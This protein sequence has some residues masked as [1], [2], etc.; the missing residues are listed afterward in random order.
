MEQTI[1]TMPPQRS[2]LGWS[3]L[4][5]RWSARLTAT[6]LLGLVL[7]IYVGEGLLGDGGP[8][9]AK[10]DWPARFMTIAFFL[11]T[12]GLAA[13]W[14]RELV[15]AVFIL[16]GMM[17][18]YSLHYHVSGKFPGGAFPLF[19]VPGVLAAVSWSLHRTSIRR[20]NAG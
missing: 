15:A 4:A 19:F 5:L 13:V 14:W 6:L 1:H 17:A 20:C 9:L 11:S 18:F 2:A 3:K 10:M 16:G 12:A 7:L 8:N